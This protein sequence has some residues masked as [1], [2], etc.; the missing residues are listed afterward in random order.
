[1]PVTNNPLLIPPVIPT[2]VPSSGRIPSSSLGAGQGA[3]AGTP[4]VAQCNLIW[5]KNIDELLNHP[6]S[7]NEQLYFGNEDEMVLYV[8]ETDGVQDVE[9]VRFSMEGRPFSYACEIRTKVGNA[10]VNYSAEL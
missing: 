1:M 4:A 8:R 3:S 10:E 5:V 9:N 6:S 7:P 2:P